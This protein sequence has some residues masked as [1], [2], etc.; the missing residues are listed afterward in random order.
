MPTRSNACWTRCLRSVLVMPRYVSG[1]STFSNT[2]RSPIRL[3]LW[4]MNPISRFRMR[5]RS[6]SRSFSTGLPLSQYPP[7][8]GESRRPRIESRVDLPHPDGPAIETNSPAL[9]SSWMPASACVSTSSVRN[10]LVTPSRRINGC[11]SSVT[12]LPSCCDSAPAELLRLTLRRG[13][14]PKSLL[15]IRREPPRSSFSFA[16][17]DVPVEV[18]EL[19]LGPAPVDRAGDGLLDLD[20][21]LAPLVAR[22]R[23]DRLPSTLVELDVE[24]AEDVPVVRL[25]DDVRFEVGRER[26][27]DLAVHR[28]ERHR[29]SGRHFPEGGDQV[30]VQCMGYGRA[31]HRG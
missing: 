4:K 1:S 2:V 26:D 31:R 17:V 9:M 6:C 8:E 18:L 22:V 30:S 15:E 7:S 11:C 25:Q 28:A 21:V 14:P 13:F 24:V 20:P 27:V 16:N 5:A 3:K 19:D 23:D 12:A 29:L 10:I